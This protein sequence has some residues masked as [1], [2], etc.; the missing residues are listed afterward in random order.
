MKVL[1]IASQKGG[2]GKTTVSLNLAFAL[3]Q[4]GR[5]VL[6]VDTDP[7]GGIGLSL[8]Q[9]RRQSRGLAEC[10][11]G[12][13]RLPEVA[14]HTRLKTLRIITVGNVAVQDTLGFGERLQDG[15]ALGAMLEPF[16]GEIDVVVI[17]TPAGFGGATMGSVRVATHMMSTLQAEPIALR[18][19]TQM[20]QVLAGLRSEPRMPKFI[21][22]VLTMLQMRDRASASSAEAAWEQLPDGLVMQPMIPRDSAF[23]A[24]SAAGVPLGLYRRDP[25]AAAALF[26]QLAVEVESRIGLRSEEG[27]GPVPLVD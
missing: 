6:L 26:E 21:G 13:A 27:D 14:L 1:T 17:D 20:L 23:L 10:L 9:P 18:S 8:A 2:V 5:N 3:A 22:F 16:A 7:Q 25:P 4:R 15:R 19:A 24:A 11:A 12:A